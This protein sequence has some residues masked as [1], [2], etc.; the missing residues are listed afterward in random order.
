MSIRRLS[1]PRRGTSLLLAFLVLLIIYYW[2]QM[3][4][5]LNFEPDA[6]FL[7][8]VLGQYIRSK[9]PLPQKAS[10]TVKMVHFMHK[11]YLVLP[12]HRRFLS[13]WR[14]VYPSYDLYF[15]TDADIE[16]LVTTRYPELRNFYKKRL[17]NPLERSDVARVLILHAFGGWYADLDAGSQLNAENI[18][19]RHSLIVP[20]EPFLHA[21]IPFNRRRLVNNAIMYSTPGHPFWMFLISRIAHRIFALPNTPRKKISAVENTGPL[22][23]TPAM[24]QFAA[25][26]AA[27]CGDLRDGLGRVFGCPYA[28]GA[29]LPTSGSG[30]KASQ[31][32]LQG[33]QTVICFS[34]TLKVCVIEAKE[35]KPTAC[36]T[37]HLPSKQLLEVMDCYTVVDMLTA[38]DYATQLFKTSVKRKTNSPHWNEEATVEARCAH[39]LVFTVFHSTAFPPD[40]FVADTSVSF[41]ELQQPSRDTWLS[42]EP[43][44]KL[45]VIIEPRGAITQ[46]QLEGRPSGLDALE[47]HHGACGIDAGGF[48]AA[49]SAFANKKQHRPVRRG[50]VRRRVHEVNGHK[51]MVTLFRQPTFC[52]LCEG[53]IWGLYYQ[54]YQCQACT[55]VVHKRC[56]LSVVTRCPQQRVEQ[57]QQ[58][59]AAVPPGGA[60]FNI[61]VPHKFEDHNYMRFTFCDHCG[62]LLYGLRKQ[63]L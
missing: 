30:E 58:A 45:R 13:S 29:P 22:I 42:L 51:F 37:R 53:F 40:D 50:A 3:G 54:G 27:S 59:A 21:M 5:K 56:H 20:L 8:P 61:N 41:E 36:Q 60:R 52:S 9:F 26:H 19:E 6:Y 63:G 4:L 48:A 16:R 31:P 46:E 24:E 25:A 23:M 15:W 14:Q 47:H 12:D 49:S 39:R 43:F 18:T 32:Q 7:D 1:W 62:S 35:L 11:S 44:G 33:P 2:N 34:G 55:C 28:S 10:P 57:Q 38:D 17:G